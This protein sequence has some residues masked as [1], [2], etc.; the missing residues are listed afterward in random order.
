VREE[1]DEVE[2]RRIRPV[3]VLDDE[4]HGRGVR[5]L[6]EQRERVL[7]HRQLR[8]GRPRIALELSERAQG[9]GEGLVRQ[10]RADE[11]DGLS[12]ENVESAGAG[13]TRELRR[14]AGLADPG[15]SLDEDRPA[16]PR[17]RSLERPL[18]LPELT[19]TAD[20]DL[21]PPRLHA[22]SIRPHDRSEKASRRHSA[23]ARYAARG[24]KIRLPARCALLPP[25]PRS[26]ETA[27][28]RSETCRQ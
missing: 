10:L 15:L 19:C 17:P 1:D 16:S 11:I 3:Q 2:R 12:H 23:F 4:Q 25:R 18:E 26:L 5:P 21:A 20:E 6:G 24:M 27:N 7:E 22:P 9:V 13:A 28:T 8:A 14:Q